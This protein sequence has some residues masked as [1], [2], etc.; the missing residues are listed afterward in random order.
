MYTICLVD[1]RNRNTI[2]G[3]GATRNPAGRFEKEHVEADYDHGVGPVSGIKTQYIDDISQTVI[4]K[5]NSPDIGFN[6]SLNPYRGCEHGCSYCFARPTHE[7]LGYSAGLDFESKIVVKRRAAE[8]LEQEIGKPGYEPETLAFSGV[9]DPYQPIERKLEITRKCLELLA[10][11]RHPVMII[12]KNALVTRD[13]DYLSE[14]ARFS[15]VGVNI[16]ITS[17]RLDLARKMEPKTSAPYER[18]EALR[19]LRAAGIPAGV[20]MGPAIPGLN[21]IEMPELM[22][23]AVHAG[24]QWFRYSTLRLPY[25]VK[26]LFLDWLDRFEPGKRQRVED[27]IRSIR[28]GKLN[29][30]KFHER[31]RGEG[32]WADQLKSL[33]LLAKRKSGLKEE[34]PVLN[35]H[36]FIP[37][38]LH[39]LDLL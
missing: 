8:L 6:R 3:R 20:I 24:A 18:L 35:V 29:N 33:Y 30:S 14:L 27:R 2:K 32:I 23:A 10:R 31:F 7:Y 16:S 19:Q 11:C 15:A 28:G 25:G 17:L 37:P 39:Q 5:N 34:L 38:G 26:D 12:T 9:T 4:S 21:E 1:S 36:N 22:A 13:I